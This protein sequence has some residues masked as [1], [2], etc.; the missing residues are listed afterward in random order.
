MITKS[1][2]SIWS[3]KKS[4]HNHHPTPTS[5]SSR[6]TQSGGVPQFLLERLCWVFTTPRWGRVHDCDEDDDHNTD[7][8]ELVTYIQDEYIFF[9]CCKTSP[10][11]RLQPTTQCWGNHRHHL[12]HHH[13]IIII[14]TILSSSLSQVS[15]PKSPPTHRHSDNLSSWTARVFRSHHKQGCHDYD[16]DDNN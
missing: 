8:L 16:G 14:I 7:N 15:E 4:H 2:Y 3:A 12:H 10:W 9:R 6:C 5:S 13:L 11:K 1:Q